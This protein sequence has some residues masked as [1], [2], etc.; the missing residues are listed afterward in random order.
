M[1]TNLSLSDVF[2]SKLGNTEKEWRFSTIM[3]NLHSTLLH[4]PGPVSII[5][6]IDE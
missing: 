1:P 4:N 6:S 3:K 2:L 5:F